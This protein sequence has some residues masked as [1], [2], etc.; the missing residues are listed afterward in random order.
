LSFPRRRESRKWE[1]STFYET[2]NIQSFE[3]RKNSPI[4]F[5]CHKML[6]I[7]PED[8]KIKNLI[9]A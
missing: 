4:N 3:D 9:S 8:T 6:S 1:N 5:F 7:R 2:I